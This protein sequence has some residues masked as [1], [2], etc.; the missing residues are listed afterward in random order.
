MYIRLGSMQ[1]QQGMIV[2]VL[3]KRG[4]VSALGAGA[5]IHATRKR[6]GAAGDDSRGLNEEVFSSGG[7][8]SALGA[9]AGIHTTRKRAGGLNKE[10]SSWAQG[11]RAEIDELTALEMLRRCA[12]KA[13]LSNSECGIK[14]PHRLSGPRHDDAGRLGGWRLKADPRHR[15][16]PPATR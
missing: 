12:G 4:A 7:A 6:A 11:N 3:T 9:G 13:L 8:V 14:L 16:R 10:V 2:G 15:R 5:G 1:V